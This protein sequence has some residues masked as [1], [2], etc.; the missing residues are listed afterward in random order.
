M[1]RLEDDRLYRQDVHAG[2]FVDHL[3]ND[4]IRRDEIDERTGILRLGGRQESA[5]DVVRVRLNRVDGPLDIGLE[6]GAEFAKGGTGLGAEDRLSGRDAP[7]STGCPY[8]R[9]YPVRLCGAAQLDQ[10]CAPSTPRSL[11]RMTHSREQLAI[12]GHLRLPSFGAFGQTR[13]SPS[14]LDGS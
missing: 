4:R 12:R 3:V 8:R 14:R 9:G 10:E 5:W 11:L 13:D 1:R 2:A 7:L 6:F